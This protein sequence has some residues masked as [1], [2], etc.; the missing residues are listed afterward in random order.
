MGRGYLCKT[1]QKK[2]A[3]I[4]SAMRHFAKMLKQKGYK[5]E[6]VKLDAPSNSGSSLKGTKKQSVC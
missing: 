1:S 2:I 5:V 6:Y 4:F 3:F